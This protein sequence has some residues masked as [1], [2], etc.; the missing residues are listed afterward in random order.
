ME[1]LSLQKIQIY[2]VMEMDLEPRQFDSRPR[3]LDN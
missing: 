3:T 2:Q 1:K